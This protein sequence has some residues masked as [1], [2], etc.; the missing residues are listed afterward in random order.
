M[1][2]GLALGQ[3]VAAPISV[4][5][6]PAGNSPDIDDLFSHPDSWARARRLT[7]GFVFSPGQIEGNPSMLSGLIAVDAFRLPKAWGLSTIL[8]VPAL[9]EWDCAARQTPSVT[10]R[11]MKKIFAEG[12]RVQ[13][14]EMD[15]PLI[16]ALGI[17]VPVCHLNINAA[18]DEVAAYAK[19]VTMDPAV[20]ASGSVPRIVDIEAYPAVSVGQ[21][22]TWLTALESSGFKPAG[23]NIDPN[24]HYIDI[25]PDAR[26]RLAKDLQELQRFLRKEGIP[27]GIIIWSGYDPLPT[28]EDYYLHAMAWARSIHEAI[29]RPD[30]VMF[31]SWVKRCSLVGRC[32][33]PKR[34][35]TSGDPIYCGTMS[36]PLNLPEEGAGAFTHTRLIID[37]TAVLTGP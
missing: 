25:H 33:G 10:V 16:S 9:K 11:L 19:S 18:A 35:C 8:G 7:D 28:D 14:L 20:Q 29:G 13:F 23:L 36:I 5:F 12:G 21:I 26:S 37:A 6:M 24:I 15:E 31:E 1:T 32:V 27:F 2:H 34:A 22:E 3:V 17:N 30:R 4:W